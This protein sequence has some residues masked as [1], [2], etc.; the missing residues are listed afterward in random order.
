MTGEE[1]IHTLIAKPLCGTDGA[2]AAA[3]GFCTSLYRNLG[4]WHDFNLREYP[5]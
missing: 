5:A 1:A 3:N 4:H 2:G